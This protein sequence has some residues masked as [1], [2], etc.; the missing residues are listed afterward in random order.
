MAFVEHL[1]DP[2]H[3]EGEFENSAEYHQDPVDHVRVEV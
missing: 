3:V 2:P 1:A